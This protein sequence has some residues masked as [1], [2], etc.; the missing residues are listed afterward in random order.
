MGKHGD[1]ITRGLAAALTGV[2]LALSLAACGDD[3]DDG[4]GEA[5]SKREFIARSNA[6][7]ERTQKKSGVVFERI[8][9]KEG[10]PAPGEEQAFLR[11]AGRFLRQGAIPI[12]SEN[13][14]GRR[15]L[16]AP[17]GDE[18]K[19]A[20]INA[21]GAKAVAGFKQIAKDPAKV[22]AL[23]RGT[24]ADPAKRW[25]TLSRQYGIEKCGG[26]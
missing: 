19:I 10:R 9:G 20:A 26:D 3:G 17:E 22:E 8:V 2:A 13:L 5:L 25:D 21:A 18:Q 11:K 7:C 16:P 4:G 6:L 12:I 14:E 23:F 1:A 24:L 15:A